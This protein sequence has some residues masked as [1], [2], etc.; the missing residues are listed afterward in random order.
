MVNESIQRALSKNEKIYKYPK[1]VWKDGVDDV[2]KENW[3]NEKRYVDFIF[4]KYGDTNERLNSSH[5][6]YRWHNHRNGTIEL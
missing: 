3:C 2:I 4:D 5:G 1:K 6:D